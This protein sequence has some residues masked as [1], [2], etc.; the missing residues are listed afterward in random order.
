MLQRQVLVLKLHA[1]H[2]KETRSRTLWQSHVAVANHVLTHEGSVYRDIFLKEVPGTKLY[3]G[4][5]LYRRHVQGT[6]YTKTH[7]CREMLQRQN[8]T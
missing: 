7:L 4:R 1:I 8:Q 2:K 3:G 5:A 6:E